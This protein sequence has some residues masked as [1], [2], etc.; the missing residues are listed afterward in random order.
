M[1]S[2]GQ[3]VRAGLDAYDLSTLL[4][5]DR[6]AEIPAGTNL[7]ITGP[8]MMGKQ[9]LALTALQQQQQ[10]GL[11]VVM[12]TSD[13]NADQLSTQYETLDGTDNLEDIYV[14]D[15][16]GT[17]GSRSFEETSNVKYVS[18]PGDLTGIG[19]GI[20]KCTNEIGAAAE[21]GLGFGVLSIS[22]LLQYTSEE[23]VF[24]FAHVMTGRIA[25]AGYLGLW[26][27]DTTSHDEQTVSTM[28]G[29][30]DYVAELRE[31]E[32]GEREMRVLGGEDALRTW[33]Q[34]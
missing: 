18:S 24:N 4:P 7:L 14:V 19:M 22:T 8:S 3:A 15:C 11:S 32:S 27:L 21:D 34:L 13:Q 1:T 5:A 33:E 25:A 28:R 2:M 12:V 16:S 20:A 30:F 9:Q 10:R 17:T 6:L 26:T 29:Q 31:A 23:R